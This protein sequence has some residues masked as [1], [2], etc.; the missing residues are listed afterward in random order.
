M[1]NFKFR[2]S[3]LR[4][5]TEQ[6]PRGL[7]LTQCTVTPDLQALASAAVMIK[8][9]SVALVPGPPSFSSVVINKMLNDRRPLLLDLEDK[10]TGRAYA[11]ARGVPVVDVLWHGDDPDRIP[12]DKLPNEYA[13][14]CTHLA[15]EGV[16][17]VKDGVDL[18]TGRAETPASIRKAAA[19]W[20][21]KRHNWIEWAAAEN[22]HPQLMVEAILK[23]LSPQ[24]SQW[25]GLGGVDYKVFVIDGKVAMIYTSTTAKARATLVHD[26]PRGAKPNAT[27]YAISFALPPWDTLWEGKPRLNITTRG[28][29]GLA[30]PTANHETLPSEP[31]EVSKLIAYAETLGA[32]TDGV[33]IDFMLTERGWVFTEFTNYPFGGSTLFEPRMYD[34]ALAEK[35]AAAASKYY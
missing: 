19:T 32:G 9:K 28:M 20:L 11:A 18:R 25:D 31:P 2:L 8:H 10:F 17:L 35:W 13:I 22:P 30:S 33:R 27:E 1:G 6:L 14:K 26:L 16:M 5:L 4:S 21:D 3:T 7:S 29:F 24:N 23:P 15:V 12:F 34:T